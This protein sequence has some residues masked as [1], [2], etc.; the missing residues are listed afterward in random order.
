LKAS[1]VQLAGRGKDNRKRGVREENI[2]GALRLLSPEQ[3]GCMRMQHVSMLF[4]VI[5]KL[6][7]PIEHEA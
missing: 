3:T 6:V 5:Y 2:D 1:E 7:V 4:T